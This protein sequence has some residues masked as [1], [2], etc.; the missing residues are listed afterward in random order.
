VGFGQT[1]K[2]I[3]SSAHCRIGLFIA[4]RV[5]SDAGAAV[6]GQSQVIVATIAVTD[7]E[8]T[9]GALD[10]TSKSLVDLS[11]R[12]H[13][14]LEEHAQRTESMALFTLH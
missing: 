4:P 6:T 14:F 9:N 5:D 11:L 3:R 7:D 12:S 2:A 1:V 8:R 10:A 13:K